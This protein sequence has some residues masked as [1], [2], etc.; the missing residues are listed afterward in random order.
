MLEEIEVEQ[1]WG[2]M[3]NWAQEIM[4]WQ[5]PPIPSC[6]THFF[7]SLYLQNKNLSLALLKDTTSC[8]RVCKTP[9]KTNSA[10]QIELTQQR[11]YPLSTKYPFW[12]KAVPF[13]IFLFGE[14]PDPDVV[15]NINNSPVLPLPQFI[16]S[17]LS[18]VTQCTNI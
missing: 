12:W 16:G 3:R 2:H 13:I 17:K 14:I 4:E 15:C 1:N 6:T 10:A 7:P 11:G 18:A 5:F 9:L 8:A